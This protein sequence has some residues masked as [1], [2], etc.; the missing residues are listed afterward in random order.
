MAHPCR[1]AALGTGVVARPELSE[2]LAADRELSDQ[3]VQAGLVDVGAD[4]GPQPRDRRLR[5]S[6]P[7]VQHVA[8]APVEKRD[9]HAVLTDHAP[10]RERRRE[11]V[12][13]ERVHVPP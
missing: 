5:D 2:A 8:H 11:R 9:T 6:L 4:Q 12:D 3:F 13:G 1:A 10:R 7:V